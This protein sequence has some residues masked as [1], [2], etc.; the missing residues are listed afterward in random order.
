MSKT[1]ILTPPLQTMINRWREFIELG[2]P[3]LYVFKGEVKASNDPGLCIPF[4]G[5]WPC[6]KCPDG[7]GVLEINE[8]LDYI[9]CD[10]CEGFIQ[11]TFQS[12][13]ADK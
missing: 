12:D 7:K 3:I 4:L 6:P 2:N 8:K 5:N 9:G 13:L 1:I 10:R 11:I